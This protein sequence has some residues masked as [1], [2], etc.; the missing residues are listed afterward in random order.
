MSIEYATHGTVI[1]VRPS[2]AR[3]SAYAAAMVPL[4]TAV[5]R[6]RG[7]AACDVQV[8]STTLRPTSLTWA[9]SQLRRQTA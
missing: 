4:F 8:S 2:Q 3:L 6:P 7:G 5:P 1:T 9:K